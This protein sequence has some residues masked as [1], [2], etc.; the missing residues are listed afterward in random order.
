MSSI[1]DNAI[2][3]FLLG[4]FRDPDMA[5]EFEQNPRQCLDSA[6]L[7]EVTTPQVERAVTQIVEQHGGGTW[8]PPS[9]SGGGGG[10]GPISMIQQVIHNEQ[11]TKIIVNGDNNN[12]NVHQARADGDGS[13]AFGGDNNGNAASGGSTAGDG[14][15]VGNTTNT[16]DVDVDNSVHGD[17]SG[18]TLDAK[19]EDNSTHTNT[20]DVTLDLQAKIP[21]HVKTADLVDPKPAPAATSST[22]LDVDMKVPSQ[23]ATSP[24]AGATSPASA[25]TSPAATAM[26]HSATL[27]PAAAASAAPAAAVSVAPAPAVAP[28]PLAAA[29]APPMMAT[30]PPA[31]VIDPAPAHEPNIG[32][33]DWMYLDHDSNMPSS[34]ISDVADAH[35]IGG[36]NGVGPAQAEPEL[37][38]GD[39]AD[40]LGHQPLDADLSGHLPDTAALPTDGVLTDGVPAYDVPNGVPNY[41]AVPDYSA[42]AAEPVLDHAVAYDPVMDAG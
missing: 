17:G 28:V 31:L 8:T 14:N 4:L 41:E 37:Y 2:M 24:L 35:S 21:D 20:S 15:A 33:N 11:I 38:R 26:P 13:M 30:V 27:S 19:L 32:D 3:E 10:G 18:N 36:P 7:R 9:G 39:P 25:A 40:V 16:T 23:L 29:V 22:G 5:R 1:T 34:E 6:G 42:H 12:I